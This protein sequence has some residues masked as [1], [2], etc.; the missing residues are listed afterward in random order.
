[1]CGFSCGVCILFHRSLSLFMYQ[2]HTVLI[3]I[4]L[5]YVLRSEIVILQVCFLFFR[6]ALAIHGLLRFQINFYVIFSISK[7]NVVG[8][9]IGIAL[10]LYIAFSGMVPPPLPS[11]FSC[12]PA[13]PG[14]HNTN[15]LG[16]SPDVECSSHPSYGTND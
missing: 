2:Y 13:H 14:P 8:F 16:E 7:K 11:P 6:I 4:T 9:L 3:T 5:L 15:F 10:N 12:K 1:M